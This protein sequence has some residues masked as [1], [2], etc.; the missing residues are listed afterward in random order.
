MAGLEDYIRYNN[1]GAVRSQPLDPKLANALSYLKDMGLTAEVFSGGQPETGPNR[2]GSHRHDDGG[3][4]DVRFYKGDKMLDWAN[5]DDVPV[6]QQIVQRGKAAGLTGFGAGPG[7]MSPGSMHLGFGT[8]AV[9]GAGGTGATAPTWLKAAFNGG[10]PLQ[11]V[12]TAGAPQGTL[13]AAPGTIM[14]PLDAAPGIPAAAPAVAAAT[15]DLGDKLGSAIFGDDLAASLKK[16]FGSAAPAEGAGKQG[17]SLMGKAMGSGDTA[18]AAADREA[19]NIQSSGNLHD[20]SA[21]RMQAGTQLMAALLAKRKPTVP[22][23][24]MGA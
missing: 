6:F 13:P 24:R 5:P 19:A 15:P 20:D 22:G 18:Q 12:L 7:Y 10:D 23:M 8:P 2:T 1:K 14:P 16:T 3:A 4:G 17:L 21:A 9:W 11:E